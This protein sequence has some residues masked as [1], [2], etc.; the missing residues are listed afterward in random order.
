MS[1]C[2]PFTPR[3][4]GPAHGLI[5][6]GTQSSSGKTAISSL[7][8]AALTE[9]CIPVQPFKVG[10]D[11]IDPG[12]H[13][14]YA[15]NCCR[16]LDT[17][18]MG[19]NEVQ[20]EVRRHGAGKISVVEG[21]MGLFDGGLPDSADGSAM[22]LAQL[23]DWPILLILPSAKAGRSLAATLRGFLEEAGPDRIAGVILNQVGGDSHRSYLCEALAPLKT[24]I[25]GALPQLDA[26]KWPER[27]LGL[28]AA[29][30][31]ALP[32]RKE[33]AAIAE[34]HLDIDSI[35]S[36]LQLA[37]ILSTLPVAKLFPRKRVA[38]A[39]DEAFHF[40]YASNLDYL[41]ENGLDPVEFSPL[42][43]RKLPSDISGL[44]FGGG[45]PEVFGAAL[46][47]NRAMRREVKSALENGL[48]CYAECGGL[49]YLAEEIIE[50]SGKRHS[51]VGVVPGAVAMTR[52][53]QNFGY[54]VAE[55]NESKTYHGHEFHY[56]R[57]E[58]EAECS[59]RWRVGRRRG[60]PRRS[61]GYQA[62]RLQAS[63]VHLFWKQS[64][65]FLSHFMPENMETQS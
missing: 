22:E 4:E 56:S 42:H 37:P 53:L 59:N 21:V 31:S 62:H 48:P 36:Q 6:A 43:D 29:Q 27:H 33:M 11:F 44:I 17:W 49:M 61:E 41:R 9:R 3:P 54:C 63:Y 55:T 1:T 46:S 18:L 14:A 52:T 60:G 13:A 23:L 51:M 58:R 45:F 57:W 20:K 47:E 28:Q 34:A 50:L 12:Y 38:I 15:A 5:L 2:S 26:L 35:L 8:L 65:G 30:E 19:V 32:S 7:L 64:P 24:P 40:Y 10:P 39:R 16:N 25:L